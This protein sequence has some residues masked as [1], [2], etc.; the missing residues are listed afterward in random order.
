M[1][2]STAEHLEDIE[3]EAAFER[4][5]ATGDWSGFET[6]RPSAGFSLTAFEAGRRDWFH[7]F[8]TEAQKERMWNEQTKRVQNGCAWCA[9]VPEPP[10]GWMPW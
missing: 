2:I 7:R 5:T 4:A 6:V 1:E 9:T 10:A 3:T 8:A